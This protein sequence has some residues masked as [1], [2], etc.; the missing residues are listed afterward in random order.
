MDKCQIDAEVR[1]FLTAFTLCMV[2]G[3]LAGL[4]MLFWPS[5]WTLGLVIIAATFLA[6]LFHR[7]QL[8]NAVIKSTDK[9]KDLAVQAT[10]QV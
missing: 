5:L 6:Y 7:I 4:A 1:R 10:P 9:D 3:L 2:F 8:M